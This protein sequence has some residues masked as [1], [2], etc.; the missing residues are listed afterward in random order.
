MDRKI[1]SR[2]FSS[3][4][5]KKKLD[6]NRKESYN[7][8]SAQMNNYN[9][10]KIK[11]RPPFNPGLFSYNK[12][13]KE[14]PKN[15]I[16]KSKNSRNLKKTKN[17]FLSN[18]YSMNPNYTK[19][20]TN[21][22]NNNNYV[23]NMFFS[24]TNKR[25]TAKNSLLSNSSINLNKYKIN[26]YENNINNNIRTF[27]NDEKPN[28][29]KFINKSINLNINLTYDKTKTNK[30]QNT[31]KIIPHY[32]NYFI[33]EP[34]YKIES[35]RML[36]EYI[37]IL[38]KKE[39][40]IKNILNKSNISEKVLNQK[41]SYK[42]NTNQNTKG[43][44]SIKFNNNNSEIILGEGK[45]DIFLNNLNS[46]Y[47]SAESGNNSSSE[48][49]YYEPTSI[50]KNN[51][52]NNNNDKIFTLYKNNKFSFINSL[53]NQKNKKINIINFL[54]VPKV[55]NIIESNEKSEKYIFIVVPDESTYLEGVE[56]YKLVWR[57][58]ES[59]EVENELSIKNI[60]DCVIN[61]KYKN[62]FNLIVQMEDLNDFN[63]EIETP[64]D[65]IC[66]YFTYGINY[67][68]QIENNKETNR[69][70]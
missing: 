12:S 67:L 26:S 38:N 40:N 47:I 25:E 2:N 23:N 60:K 58:M 3:K 65:E 49:D 31:L 19:S 62:R 52:T 4:T 28:I 32:K 46:N 22:Q 20:T 57:N 43:N 66:E 35:R 48:E 70:L 11:I 53:N 45:K 68:S 27:D 41:F 42:N 24:S 59:N 16:D 9:K 36:L 44:N 7:V 17:F 63:F 8:Q 51:N 56:S 33:S 39:K 1:K 50:N 6:Y 64:N 29:N 54:C 13:I 69:F 21:D 61:K 15:E 18:A 37:K 10:N 5:G 30:E 34:K 14:L 55:L